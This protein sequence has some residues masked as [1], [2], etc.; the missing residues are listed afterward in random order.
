MIKERG[1]AGSRTILQPAAPNPVFL[2]ATLLPQPRPCLV[3]GSV[4]AQSLGLRL[5]FCS[6]DGGAGGVLISSL[7]GISHHGDRD[8]AGVGAG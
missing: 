8:R 1:L 2:L 7:K 4:S 5:G 6:L 3:L